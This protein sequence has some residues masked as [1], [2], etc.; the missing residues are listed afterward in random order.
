VLLRAA[1]CTQGY[2]YVYTVYH[3]RLFT[4]GAKWV[5]LHRR[6]VKGC[7]V[8]LTSMGHTESPQGAQPCR[9]AAQFLQ[10]LKIGLIPGMFFMHYIINTIRTYL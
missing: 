5:H 3:D 6:A 4:L 1:F 2:L 9:Q 8:F 7:G 10:Q